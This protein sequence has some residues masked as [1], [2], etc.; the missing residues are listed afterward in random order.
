MTTRG[1][2]GLLLSDQGDPNFANVSALLHFNGTDGSTTFT[3]QT[4]KTWSASGNAQ[5]DTAQQKFGSASALFDGA[6]DFISTSNSSDFDFGSGNFTIEFFIR[7]NAL[8]TAAVLGK[9]L[10]TNFGPFAILLNTS[11]IE[12]Y[13]STSGS[14]W[15]QI[16]SPTISTGTWYH[17]AAVRDGTSMRLFL[18]GTQVTPIT[19]T[20]SLMTNTAGVYLG[21]NSGGTQSFNGWID[22]LR[23]T[24]GVARY[25]AN[26]TPPT[27]E[28]P[29]S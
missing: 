13:F 10:T 5:L 1:H 4:G 24:K 7:A 19:L 23:I 6:G 20:G 29:D 16:N 26:F 28:F 22:E 8:T 14:G 21:S 27:A 15:N 11:R 17:V 25:T 9:R 18:N 12:C 2:H 3:D